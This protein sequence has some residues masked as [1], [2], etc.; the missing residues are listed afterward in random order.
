MAKSDIFFIRAE[1]NQPGASYQDVEIDLGAYVNLGVKSSTLLRVHAVEWMI[2]DDSAPMSGPSESGA[3]MN[4]GNQITTQ[5]QTA[6][7]TLADK[8]LMASQR[9]EVARTSTAGSLFIT[10]TRDVG[11]QNWLGK[12]YLVGV[13]TLFLGTGSDQAPGSGSYTVSCQLMCSLETATQSNAVAL[14][15]SQQ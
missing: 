15:L 7:V 14:A 2:S 9:Y 8:S 10:D 5:Q 6:L 1:V 4:I 3:I 12:G 11:P 13:D